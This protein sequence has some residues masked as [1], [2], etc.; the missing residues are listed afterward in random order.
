MLDVVEF[1]Q[2]VKGA[3]ARIEKEWPTGG[4]QEQYVLAFWALKRPEMLE[5]LQRLQ[6]AEKLAH[7]FAYKA[8]EAQKVY[9]AAGMSLADAREQAKLDW[10][11]M[12]P[13][14]TDRLPNLQDTDDCAM[15][16]ESLSATSR[17][18]VPRPIRIR[19][20]QH[21]MPMDGLERA[22]LFDTAHVLSSFQA[23]AE[24]A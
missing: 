14:V 3:S 1:L 19:D 10:L 15:D 24:P 8:L 12:E 9:L 16:N 6:I 22:S 11:L 18:P 5:G 21:A 13:E 17:Q 2:W 7:V 20:W 23:H 4:K